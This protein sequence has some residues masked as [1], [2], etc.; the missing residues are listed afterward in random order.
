M[1]IYSKVFEIVKTVLLINR[2]VKY[3]QNK[4]SKK[5]NEK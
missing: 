4:N 2:V 1:N 3:F 5:K